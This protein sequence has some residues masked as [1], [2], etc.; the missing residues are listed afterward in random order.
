MILIRSNHESN[1][2]AVRYLALLT[3]KEMSVCTLLDTPDR[4][5]SANQSCVKR[6]CS[7][8]RRGVSNRFT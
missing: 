5:V 6:V 4:A 1:S 8:L 3:E 2:E 7:D